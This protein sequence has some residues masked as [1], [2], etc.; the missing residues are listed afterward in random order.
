M[1]V[2]NCRTGDL[3]LMTNP[4]GAPSRHI[5]RSDMPLSSMDLILDLM[6]FSTSNPTSNFK[7]RNVG[8]GGFKYSGDSF[9]LFYRG[10]DGCKYFS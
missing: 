9:H 5:Q 10:M 7:C 2:D 1:T 4:K 3:K 6:R 8:G